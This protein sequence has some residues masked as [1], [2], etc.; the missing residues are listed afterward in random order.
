MFVHE[1]QQGFFLCTEAILGG[2]TKLASLGTRKMRNYEKSR[3]SVSLENEA[4]VDD[5]IASIPVFGDIRAVPRIDTDVYDREGKKTVVTSCIPFDTPFFWNINMEQ[6]LKDAITSSIFHHEPIC[7][8]LAEGCDPN[9]EEIYFLTN[10]TECGA[11]VV[12]YPGV[13]KEVSKRFGGSDMLMVP[14]SRTEFLVMKS[15]DDPAKIDWMLNTVKEINENPDFKM[16][17]ENRFLSNQ[18]FL[19][20]V[21]DDTIC[22]YT[23]LGTDSENKPKEFC[24]SQLF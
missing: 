9:A 14:A 12:L 24:C 17:E 15:T 2:K 5:A 23:G 21:S 16:A 7:I 19:Y 20:R 1:V 13:L 8:N 22:Q 6:L 18:L 3:L 11:A 10:K 4:K